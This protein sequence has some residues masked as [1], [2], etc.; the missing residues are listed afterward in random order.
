MNDVIK[1]LPD[2]V[3]NQ[4]AAG[5]VIQR[6]S[7]AIKELL[8]NAIDAQATQIDVL[9]KESGKALIQIT[10]NGCGMSITD[11]R[12]AF[13]RHA[14]SKITKAEDL[15]NIYTMGFRGEALASIAA[16][17]QVELKT[18]KH[19]EDIGTCLS[20]EGAVVKEHKPVAT[21]AGSSFSIKNL[22]FNIPARRNFLKSDAIEARHIIEEFERI[23]IAH[24]QVGFSLHINGNDLYILN[25]GNLK[26]R[27]TSIFGNVYN[28]KIVPISEETSVVKLAGYIIKPE[29]A[30]KTRGEQFL[31]VN[32]RFIKSAY[33]HHAVTAAFDQLLPKDSFAS[34]FLFVEVDPKSIDINIHP[35]KTEIKFDDE[36]SVYA[37][38]K[39]AVKKAIGQ[40]GIA[41]LL[42]FEREAS[43]DL[44]YAKLKE[45][46]V[47]PNIK[48]DTSYNPFRSINKSGAQEPEKSIPNNQLPQQQIDLMPINEKVTYPCFQWQIKYLVT[49][50]KSG[51][52]IIDIERAHQRINFESHLYNIQHKIKAS[53]QLLFPAI[54]NCNQSD[55]TILLSHLNHLAELGFSIKRKSELSF[56]IEGLPTLLDQEREGP[57]IESLIEHFKND[58]FDEKE[59]QLAIARILAMHHIHANV[60]S[61]SQQAMQSLIDRLFACKNAAY[62]PDGKKIFTTITSE[63][64]F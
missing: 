30:R 32:K 7:S 56:V 60:S 52:V 6:P 12:M 27:I 2:S 28:E 49:Q 44:P 20:I 51:L 33:L 42:D 25:A 37:I 22:F 13:E 29:F 17:A 62:T 57:I 9:V 50:N 48:V 24:P 14:T 26:Q 31:F 39:A 5:E 59:S 15:F 18:K 35:T 55:A 43:F 63:N 54:F 1:L 11:A 53:Q 4:I 3:A 64:L 36:R 21:N 61:L 46:P 10:D 16:I 41:P 45:T 38:I 58:T 19:H 40:Y 47:L 34:Y 23:A 8:E